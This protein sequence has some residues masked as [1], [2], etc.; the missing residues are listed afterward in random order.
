M[1]AQ[2]HFV[3][4]RDKL[5][6]NDIAPLR[7]AVESM[8]TRL[9]GFE[10]STPKSSSDEA[11]ARAMAVWGDR[12]SGHAAELTE[13]LESLATEINKPNALKKGLNWM[14]ALFELALKTSVE[15]AVKATFKAGQG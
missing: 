10:L 15:A 8:I 2:S 11:F 12:F 5:A 4:V 9:Q 13:K 3:D 1:F 6:L 14:N 7:E